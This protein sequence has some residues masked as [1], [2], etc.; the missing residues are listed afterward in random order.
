MRVEDSTA[1]EMLDWELCPLVHSRGKL[2]AAV[3]DDGQVW[4]RLVGLVEALISIQFDGL[5]AKGEVCQNFL[6]HTLEVVDVLERVDEY[7][8]QVIVVGE[9]LAPFQVAL[10]LWVVFEQLAD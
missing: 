5:H 2:H 3:E 9:Q 6:A 8:C 10:K 4:I 1:S 7:P